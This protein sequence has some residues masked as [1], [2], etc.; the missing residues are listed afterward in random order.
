MQSSQSAECR[1]PTAVLSRAE[2]RDRSETDPES[3]IVDGV[4]VLAEVRTVEPRRPRRCRRS[5]RPPSRRPGSSPAPPP[6]R[7][8]SAAPPRKVAAQRPVRPAAG[9]DLLPIAGSRSFLVDVHV[10]G[11]RGLSTRRGG[12]VE[13]RVEVRPR[14]AVR[15]AAPQRA[16]RR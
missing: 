8:S 7:W 9:G 10:I 2:S 11:K 13:V 14:L 4:P 12:G 1:P 15:A 16:G 5:R 3:E 6:S